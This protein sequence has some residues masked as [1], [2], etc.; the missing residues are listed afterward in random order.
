[1]ARKDRSKAKQKWNWAGPTLSPGVSCLASRI[2]CIIWTVGLDNPLS[3]GVL[4]GTA[5]FIFWICIYM[6][7]YRVKCLFLESL[8]LWDFHYI[9]GFPFTCSYNLLGVPYRESDPDIITR[10][11]SFSETLIW[12]YDTITL[13]SKQIQKHRFYQFFCQAE[14]EVFHT[15]DVGSVFENLP[16]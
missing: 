9:S 8:V 12:R 16:V 5:W 2:Y 4:T 6:Y 15:R 1:M 7:L 11:R 10:L 14:I 3:P 13:V